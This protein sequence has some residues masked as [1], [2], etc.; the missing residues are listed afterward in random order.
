[1]WTIRSVNAYLCKLLR[2]FNIENPLIESNLFLQHYLGMDN[3]E[4]ILNNL[5]KLEQSSVDHLINLVQRRGNGEPIQYIIGKEQFCSLSLKIDNR[6][7]IPRP[8]TEILVNKAIIEIKKFKNQKNIQCLDVGTGSG[9]IAISI[10]KEIDNINI[11]ATDIST[12]A[13]EIA[14][15]NVR[16]YK[17]DS[18]ITL[19]Q[20]NLIESIKF[21][22]DIIVANLPYIPTKKL[23]N[24]QKE[25]TWEPTIALDGGLDGL[26]LISELFKQL[27]AKHYTDF[28]LLLEIDSSQSVSLRRLVEKYFKKAKI[29]ISK[30]FHGYP[31]FALI[32]I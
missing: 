2:S 7:L 20:D 10:A 18:K 23:N 30:D 25:V 28:I 26:D 12:N 5:E 22:P 24:L 9:A 17:L 3:I 27:N 1:M 8:E 21:K 11:V 13:L 32:K 14:R 4:L 6:V 29:N 16:K 19:K 15:L 31:R